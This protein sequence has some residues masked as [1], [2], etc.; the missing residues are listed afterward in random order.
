MDPVMGFQ[1]QVKRPTERHGGEETE[2]DSQDPA[3]PAT[4]ALHILPIG[5]PVKG[6]NQVSPAEYLPS[7]VM[8][9]ALT[10]VGG[11]ALSSG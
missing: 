4:H 6:S 3:G 9:T 2:H 10:P 7:S 5:T 8:L 11:A 1:C